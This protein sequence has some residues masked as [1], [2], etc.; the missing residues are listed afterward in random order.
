MRAEMSAKSEDSQNASSLP[1]IKNKRTKNERLGEGE[2]VLRLVRL[3]SLR[4]R[5]VRRRNENLQPKD[6][7]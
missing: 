2:L 4:G 6:S 5:G 7:H 3:T 1:T